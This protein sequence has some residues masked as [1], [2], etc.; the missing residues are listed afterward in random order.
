[1]ETPCVLL[2]V[3]ITFKVEWSD[4]YID[5]SSTE[6]RLRVLH[7]NRMAASRVFKNHTFTSEYILQRG[8]RVE[9]RGGGGEGEAR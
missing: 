7:G 9:R 8:S 1:M 5:F 4:I 6:E 2:L 3:R